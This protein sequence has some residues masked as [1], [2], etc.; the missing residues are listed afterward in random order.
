MPKRERGKTFLLDQIPPGPWA[1]VKAR[2]Q[3]EGR[4]VKFIILTLLA[5]YLAHGL[6]KD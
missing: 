3:R 6:R 5:E 1:K 4:S 2:A